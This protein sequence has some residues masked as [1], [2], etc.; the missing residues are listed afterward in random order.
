MPD[1]Y[2]LFR[3]VLFKVDP[4]QA[5]QLTLKA[6]KAGLVPPVQPVSDSALEVKLW[7]LKFPNPVGLSAGFDKQAEVVGPAFKMG[8]GFVE[9]G[10]VTPKPQEGN[11][12][13]RVFRDP[14]TESVINRMGF[15]NGGVTIFKS[16]LE[17]FLAGGSR[18]VGVVGINI[19]MNK[20]QT[21][22]AKD[23]TMLINML[24]PMA[25]YITI[26]ISSPN[27]PGLRDLQKRE[28]LLELLGAVLE[29]RRKSCG[30]HPPPL[31]LKL[32]PDLSEEQQDEIAKTVLE[33]G[34]DGLILT[35]TTLDRPDSLP[36]DFAAEK[37]GLSGRLVRDKSTAVIRNFYRLTGG[38]LP[39][40][41][42]GG[43]STGSDAYE[44]IKAGASLV[45]LYTSLVFKGPGVA[46]S[47]NQELLALLK[48]D[49]FKTIS[50]AV[51]TGQKNRDS[52]AANGNR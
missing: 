43:I 37:G 17:Q 1:L 50:Q 9:A 48:K 4:E 7:N 12:K 44:K 40:V 15:P 26:N 35:N 34:M 36:G 30:D 45:Q 11:P 38:K 42:V 47:I 8:F 46:N 31:L 6:L 32:A 27:T 29:E 52:K 23:Y 5:H 22:P 24:G 21:E 18:P 2:N 16:N 33:A 28:P 49:G 20:T 41:G 51:G 3:P 10:T 25:D 19:G 39:I 14:K 13:P